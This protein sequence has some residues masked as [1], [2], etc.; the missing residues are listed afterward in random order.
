MKTIPATVNLGKMSRTQLETFMMH[1]Q[2]ELETCKKALATMHMDDVETPGM[3]AHSVVIE[4]LFKKIRA[5][6]EQGKPA[7]NVSI[8]ILEAI[9]VWQLIQVSQNDYTQNVI[10]AINSTI[11]KQLQ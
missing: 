7:C 3:V 9:A 10:L 8:D 5:R 2:A 11:H 1:L 4:R 6:W